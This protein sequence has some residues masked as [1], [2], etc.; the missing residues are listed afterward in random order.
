[1]NEQ[2]VSTPRAGDLDDVIVS[3]LGNSRGFSKNGSQ[4]GMCKTSRH[5]Y[6][7][8]SSRVENSFWKR[9][10]ANQTQDP[11]ASNLKLNL[12]KN[13]DVNNILGRNLVEANMKIRDKEFG[14]SVITNSFL[15]APIAI[16]IH[17]H[18]LSANINNK[19]I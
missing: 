19:D 16:N 17:R 4:V 15:T 5:N 9:E 12:S 11:L 3:P 7:P 14:Q 6:G 1:L 18:K 2:K 13:Q 8:N 10:S